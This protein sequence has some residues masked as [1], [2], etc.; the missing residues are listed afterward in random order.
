MGLVLR[1]QNVLLNLKFILVM[2]K[3]HKRKILVLEISRLFQLF[4]IHTH[5]HTHTHKYLFKFYLRPSKYSFPYTKQ[6]KI[7]PLGRAFLQMSHLKDICENSH[8]MV[9]YQWR[10]RCQKSFNILNM[11]PDFHDVLKLLQYFQAIIGYLRSN[12]MM[13]FFLQKF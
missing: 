1:I 13:T 7:S 11:K 3:I 2:W 4:K 12:V 5:T 8:P 9:S 10:D 6:M